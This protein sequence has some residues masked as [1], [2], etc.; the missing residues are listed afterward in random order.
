[1]SREKNVL[2]SFRK[3]GQKGGLQDEYANMQKGTLSV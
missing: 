1:M 3:N 2:R